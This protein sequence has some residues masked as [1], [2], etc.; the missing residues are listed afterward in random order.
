ML[1]RYLTL[2]AFM[3]LTACA[4][5]SLKPEY[6][7][8]FAEQIKP[9]YRSQILNGTE[10]QPGETL[11]MVDDLKITGVYSISEE[12]NV[13]GGT[14]QPCQALEQHTLQCRWTDI[15]GSG[16]LTMR[17][18]KDYESFQG[19]WGSDKHSSSGFPWN[20]RAN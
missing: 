11:F 13:V 17:F 1:K 19:F 9:Y 16:Y 4:A 7:Q 10:M 8:A 2:F 12:N 6:Q 15:Y 5:Q 14:L 3:L 20:G 18:S